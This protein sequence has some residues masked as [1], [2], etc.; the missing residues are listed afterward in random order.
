VPVHLSCPAERLERD[1]GELVVATR[2][3]PL[4]ADRVVLCT[5][6]PT[7]AGLLHR[8]VPSAAEGLAEL[9]Y[10]SAAMVT[11]SVPI[12]ALDRP[13]DAS[14]FLVG[15]ADRLPTV[16]ACSWASAKW[17]HLHDPDVA[18]LRASV[19]RHGDTAALELPD[20]ELLAAVE[21]DLATTMG[22]ADRPLAHRITR[23]WD[24]LPQ[25]RPG[26]LA[27]V[28]AWREAVRDA[29]PGIV[30]AGAAYDGLGLPACIR[31]GRRAA[32]EVAGASSPA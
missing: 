8:L 31:Q 14:G 20:E 21:A 13:L 32:D 11:L 2:L 5:P 27:R 25:Y 18:V 15:A 17:A 1:G 24:G 22:L 12:S 19:G 29:A 9:D 23:W 4:S 28:R 6:A 7:T 10:A 3:G 30:L 16:T 26:H